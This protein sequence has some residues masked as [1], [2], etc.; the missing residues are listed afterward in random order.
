[1]EEKSSVVSGV[2]AVTMKECDEHGCPHCGCKDHHV[3]SRGEGAEGRRCMKC[4]RKYVAL[5]EGVA[6]SPIGVIYDKAVHFPK[7]SAH[8]LGQVG[9][10]A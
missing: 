2:I 8:P 6:A 3:T 1:M 5:P 4:G 9:S 10:G 7:L